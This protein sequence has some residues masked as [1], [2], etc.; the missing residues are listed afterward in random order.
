MQSDFF[1][2]VVS[3]SGLLC[4]IA[5]KAFSAGYLGVSKR[6]TE[7]KTD[8]KSSS[9]DTLPESLLVSCTHLSYYEGNQAC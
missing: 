9:G 4:V 2:Q 6:N 3:S 8:K 7:Q 5:A 1:C